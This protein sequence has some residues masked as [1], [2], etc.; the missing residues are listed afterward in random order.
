MQ[1]LISSDS[2]I[3][4]CILNS[5]GIIKL[6]RLKDCCYPA[7]E[8]GFLQTQTFI[9][10]CFQNLAVL[11]SSANDPPPKL[12]QTSLQQHLP[13][14]FFLSKHVKALKLT[15][16]F[17]VGFFFNFLGSICATTTSG[18]RAASILQN[19]IKWAAFFL[20]C[21]RLIHTGCL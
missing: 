6:I 13:P 10:R 19:R 9:C 4:C 17:T 3:V 7:V 16:M 21:N 15:E 2:K 5:M 8:Q 18:H 14:F 11:F 12:I 20:S 1:H